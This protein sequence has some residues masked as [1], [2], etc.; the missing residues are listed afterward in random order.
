MVV[1]SWSL[2]H[3]PA[4]LWVKSNGEDRVPAGGAKTQRSG[5][6]LDSQAQRSSLH[7]SCLGLLRVSSVYFC[8]SSGKTRLSILA[9]FLFLYCPAFAPCSRQLPLGYFQIYP[10]CP[11]FPC[12][13]ILQLCPLNIYRPPKTNV[14]IYSWVFIPAPWRCHH[15]LKL[16]KHILL[17]RMCLGT[18]F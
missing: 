16:D 7:T 10:I 13:L 18:V 2:C 12:E 17:H 15:R 8:Q 9:S 5:S 1:F 6:L 3:E 4:S 14:S 11:I